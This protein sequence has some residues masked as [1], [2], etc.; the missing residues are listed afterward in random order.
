M[1][2]KGYERQKIEYL[3]LLSRYYVHERMHMQA[4]QAFQG[5]F[6]TLSGPAEAELDQGGR[7]TALANFALYLMISPYSNEQVNLLNILSE[8]Y[9]RDLQGQETVLRFVQK[10]L[11]HELMPLNEADV[12][13][14]IQDFEPFRAET[15][16]HSQHY[17]EF[18]RQII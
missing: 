3:L 5:V 15:E 10:F 7:N 6:D 18:I 4:A 13:A 9:N 11:A 14:A 12:R 17:K 2:E 16:N 1:E 8:K